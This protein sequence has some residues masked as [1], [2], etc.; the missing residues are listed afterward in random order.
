MKMGDSEED[1]SPK[2]IYTNL[3]LIRTKGEQSFEARCEKIS[4]GYRTRKQTAI[5][6]VI[7]LKQTLNIYLS[8]SICISHENLFVCCHHRQR[9]VLNF[10][11]RN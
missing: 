1:K 11:T 7:I 4:F 3:Y 10:A 2:L 5:I 8:C 6:H 9:F